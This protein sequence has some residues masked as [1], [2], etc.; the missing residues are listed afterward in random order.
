MPLMAINAAAARGEE[1]GG[2][3]QIAALPTREKK[4]CTLHTLPH[5][6][7]YILYCTCMS[8]IDCCAAQAR[9]EGLC[10]K[11]F[12]KKKKRKEGLCVKK[13]QKRPGVVSKKT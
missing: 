9:K 3:A 7:Y 4:V 8:M 10:V 1:E 13:F 2:A 11:S 5:I 6:L 12:N